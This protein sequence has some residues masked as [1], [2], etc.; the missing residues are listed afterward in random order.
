M[1]ACNTYVLIT[2][3]RNE[4]TYIEKTIQS[5]INQTILPLKWVIVSDGSTD[6]TDEIVNTYL[7]ANP[8]MQLLR[9]E[10]DNQRNFGSK[11][12]AFNAGYAELKNVDYAFI[13]NLDADISFQP[14]YFEILLQEFRKNERLGVAGGVI[15]DFYKGD[16]HQQQTS[17][18]SVAGAVQLFRRECFEKI[19]GL[20][21]LKDGLEDAIAEVTARMHGWATRSYDE[22][23]V[24]HPRSVGTEGRSNSAV[25]LRSGKLDYMFGLHPLYQLCRSLQIFFKPPI[26]IGSFLKLYNYWLCV[27]TKTE[28]S[29]SKEFIQYLRQEE[30]KKAIGFLKYI[31]KLD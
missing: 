5:V 14:D 4:A 9:K 12:R 3:A 23:K 16:F 25:A 27:F 6:G 17:L 22:L 24:L 18:E 11:V 7:S 21:P 2:P 31:L 19:G 10:G 20:L 29:V 15:Y 1:S 30:K 26:F 13:G 8:F 28:R